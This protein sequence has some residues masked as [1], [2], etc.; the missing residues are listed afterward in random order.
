MVPILLLFGL[1]YAGFGVFS[2]YL[3]PLLAS[4]GLDPQTIGLALAAGT[5]VKLAI[6]PL[7]ARHADRRKRVVL[8]L[9][10]A[11]LASGVA[12]ASYAFPVG[13]AALVALTLIQAAVLA[14]AAPFADAVAVSAAARGN[15]A[16]G[17]ARGTGSAAFVAGTLAS[18]AL[19]AAY[20]W[21]A[22]AFGQALF[23][24]A[25]GLL[26]FRA[27]EPTAAVA[28][29]STD[30]W[31]DLLAIRPFRQIMIIAALVLGSHAL[32]DAFAVIAWTNAGVSPRT[33]SLLWSEGVVAEIVVFFALGPWLFARLGARGA[34]AVSLVAALLRWTA[35]ALTTAPEIMALTEPLHG[36]TFA[37]LHLG[38]MGII[39][40]NV[41]ADLAASAQALYG[42]VAVGA[43]SAALT[44]ASGA[45]FARYGTGGFAF[46]AALC[47]LA[48]PFVWTLREKPAA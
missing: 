6:T 15:F 19:V 16:Y 9:A 29:P 24:L 30:T 47:L 42:A 33:I 37:L 46:M 32:H 22:A 36:F 39:A 17:F 44:A 26:A 1:I 2:P 14:P 8:T 25:A 27:P 4:R 23:L 18:G 43:A 10:L 21:T 7:L 41:P 45:I 38:C 13:G 28:A 31:R 11:L 40:R 34:L 3:P 35:M 20:G 5:L 48:A 12:V